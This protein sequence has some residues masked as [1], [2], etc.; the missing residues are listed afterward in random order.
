MIN[1]AFLHNIQFIFHILY[2]VFSRPVFLFVHIIPNVNK[3]QFNG[4]KRQRIN[5]K[6][7]YSFKNEKEQCDK[8]NNSPRY[9]DVYMR[10][11]YKLR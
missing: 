6:K 5:C 11:S 10:N 3:N 2:M 4:T 8:T 9:G 1:L 7:R